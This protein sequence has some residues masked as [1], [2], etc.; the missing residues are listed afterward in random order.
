MARTFLAIVSL[1]DRDADQRVRA[2][3][4]RLEL[5]CG[6]KGIRLFP[7][8]HFTWMGAED[9]ALEKLEQIV[10]RLAGMIPPMEV[11]TNGLGL[12]TGK[13]PVIYIPIVKTLG[14]FRV[15]QKVWDA[16]QGDMERMHPYYAPDQWAPHITLA[17][18]DITENNLGCAMQQLSFQSFEMVIQVNNLAVVYQEEGKTG[19]LGKRYPL[20]GVAF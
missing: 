8:P 16:A 6:V 9:C 3:H 18:Q 1:L 19:E 15:H 20:E 7:Y 13:E 14:L 17:L 5:A 11:T 10:E 2:I 12:F 4:A